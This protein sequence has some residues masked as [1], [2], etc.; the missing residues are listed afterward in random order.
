MILPNHK[1]QL[2]FFLSR[3]LVFPIDKVGF[4]WYRF[5]YPLI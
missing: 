3:Y 4:L 1:R 2:L 5:S